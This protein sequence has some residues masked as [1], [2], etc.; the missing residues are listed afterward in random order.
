[1][2]HGS[3]M[4]LFAFLFGLTAYSNP[5]NPGE[6]NSG[7]EFNTTLGGR[8]NGTEI[9]NHTLDEILK[10]TGKA[11]GKMK[12]SWPSKYRPV[13]SRNGQVGSDLDSGHRGL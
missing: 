10:A 4:A 9:G 11:Y 2:K 6:L 8:L 5:T 13:A 3:L 7:T 1:M 12:T